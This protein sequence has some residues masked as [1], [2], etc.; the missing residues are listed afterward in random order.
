MDIGHTSFSNF[1]VSLHVEAFK[2]DLQETAS[3]EG[4]LSQPII[5]RRSTLFRRYLLCH[6]LLSSFVFSDKRLNINSGFRRYTTFTINNEV[7]S[8]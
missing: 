1:K 3:T 2:L 5:F 8:L 4:I 6:G 7:N